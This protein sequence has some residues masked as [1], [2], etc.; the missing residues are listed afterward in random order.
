MAKIFLVKQFP[1]WHKVVE[2]FMAEHGH[3]VTSTDSLM[4]AK[5]TDLSQFDLVLCGRLFSGGL[6]A[7]E[8]IKEQLQKGVNIALFSALFDED[9]RLPGI[10][11]SDFSEKK[12][13]LLELI[14]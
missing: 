13:H 3:Q 9:E 7:K 2:E 12:N 10:N 8:W 5:K 11:I 4:E 14:P 1:E 6:D